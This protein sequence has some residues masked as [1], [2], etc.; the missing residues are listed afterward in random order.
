MSVSPLFFAKDLGVA[1]VKRLV[2]G[3]IARPDVDT[4][5]LT[6]STEA[7]VTREFGVPLL[8]GMDAIVVGD[9][10]F[11]L[12]VSAQPDPRETEYRATDS[13]GG[14]VFVSLTR[15][16]PLIKVGISYDAPVSPPATVRVVI[17]TA[18]PQ[19]SGGFAA[20]LPLFASPAF[21][22]PGPMFNSLLGGLTLTN[23]AGG[24]QLLTLPPSIGSAWLIQIATAADA[25]GPGKLTP[26]NIIPRVTSVMTDAVPVNLRV[27]LASDSGPVVLWSGAGAFVRGG[28]AQVVSFVPMAQRHLAA[29]LKQS[30]QS[31]S[32]TA[33]TIP[34]VFQ[35]DSPARVEVSSKRLVATYSLSALDLE[36]ASLRLGGSWIRV[37]LNAAAGLGARAGSVDVSARLQPRE[38]N[39]VS[40]DFSLSPDRSGL[41][42]TPG[43]VAATAMPFVP[44]QGASNG[45]LLPLASVRVQVRAVDATELVL[46]VRADAAGAPGGVLAGPDVKQLTQGLDDWVEFELARPLPVSSGG[47]PVWVCL[48]LTRGELHWY[49]Q[50]Q[51]TNPV[52]ISK[53]RGS[54]WAEPETLL[55]PRGAPL[56]QLFHSVADPLPEPIIRVRAADQLVSEQL[57][58][59]LV[60]TGPREFAATGV[61]LPSALLNLLSV[62][63][64]SGRV[65]TPVYLFSRSVLDLTL[66]NARISYD[67][68]Q[69]RATVS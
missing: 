42:L 62:H 49:A 23:V 53:D 60:R 44:P 52:R 5:E 13:S 36:P 6:S 3:A 27:V 48:R 51:G 14:G 31:G 57:A 16:A 34:L 69:A 68:Y 8:A 39:G 11:N 66:A 20:G 7:P 64:G 15:P 30:K 28:Q 45:T 55:G 21:P 37:T 17:R 9:A 63:S 41:R 38:L 10:S 35:S 4:I 26:L 58:A 67:P 65:G 25:D 46:E 12:N 22:A 61:Q 1:Q 54:T 47:A 33:L 40:P 56:T 59:E 24:G 43:T 29:R 2:A 19:S 50:T 18:T 32:Q